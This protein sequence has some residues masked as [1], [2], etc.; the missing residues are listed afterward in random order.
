MVVHDD[1]FVTDSCQT[2]NASEFAVKSASLL[3][4]AKLRS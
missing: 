2:V 4:I 1:S 3:I